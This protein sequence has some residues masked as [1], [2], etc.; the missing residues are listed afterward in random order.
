[1]GFWK[2]RKSLRWSPLLTDSCFTWY[3][4]LLY[5]VPAGAEHLHAQDLRT[6]LPKEK[7]LA[8]SK[9]FVAEADVFVTVRPGGV[10]EVAV[11]PLSHVPSLPAVGGSDEG[12]AA[13][14]TSEAIGDAA[15]PQDAS[16]VEGIS[17]A[18]AGDAAGPVPAQDLARLAEYQCASDRSIP[19]TGCVECTMSSAC[20]CT[21]FVKMGYGD[22]WSEWIPS[23]G[24]TSCSPTNFGGDPLPGQG[25]V[26]MCQ[27]QAFVCATDQ[28]TPATGCDDCIMPNVCT[29]DGKVR[30]GFGTA[31]TPWVQT[32]GPIDCNTDS[33]NADPFPGHAKQ[34]QCR[35]SV[36]ALTA[37]L[38]EQTRPLV[39][40]A[41][42]SAIVVVCT[43]YFFIHAALAC[44]RSNNQFAN[45]PPT[46]LERELESTVSWQS[47]FGPMLCS[48]LLTARQRVQT[49]TA[50]HPQEYGY[51][52]HYL[53]RAAV[54]CTLAYVAL[55]LCHFLSEVNAQATAQIPAHEVHANTSPIGSLSSTTLVHVQT[56]SQVRATKFWQRASHLCNFVAYGCL[57]V[58]IVGVS[59]LKEPPELMV[60]AGR[61]P[62]RIGTLC[63]LVL[64]CGY[65]TVY[66]VLFAVRLAAVAQMERGGPHTTFGLEVMKLGAS[67][68]NVAPMICAL[69]VGLQLS[70]D[71][72]ALKLPTEAPFYM[73]VCTAS[74]VMQV[75]LL[76]IAPFLAKAELQATGPRGELDFVT[77][78]HH[79]FVFISMVRWLAMTA[80][81]IGV[82]WFALVLLKLDGLPALMQ[83]LCELAGVYFFAYL[84]LWA[85]VTAQ[86]VFCDGLAHIVRAFTVAKDTVVFCPMLAVLCIAAWARAHEFDT[87]S[88]QVGQPQGYV[89]SSIK[90]SITAVA[91]QLI[92]VIVS[93]AVLRPPPAGGVYQ[94]PCEKMGFTQPF[95]IV[96][97]IALIVLHSSVV[98]TIVGICLLRPQNATGFESMFQAIPAS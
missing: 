2:A 82:G 22:I 20:A 12:T 80:L 55:I 8:A 57:T 26:C 76:I 96:Y 40:D 63:S 65:F 17:I 33:F 84:M 73:L 41:S 21:G 16:A 78:N 5:A 47:Y 94:D 34:C 37:S 69:F 70:A 24:N 38:V 66:L 71:W 28:L 49:L 13:A 39:M 48:L 72:L 6:L 15:I 11:H 19:T 7:L 83:P 59:N 58:I 14:T 61:T 60:A 88:G 30:F 92:V 62:A 87:P 86:T 10:T 64:A 25:K 4:A 18:S 29:C 95:F 91:V 35:P 74:V 81:Y 32:S 56:P 52:P 51:P 43:A 79:I 42:L 44:V 46:P 31:W 53:D 97:H 3:L 54:V 85:S 67:A 50:G 1:M 9:G 98:L 36:A 77:R 68:A 89:Q 75:V 93:G 23:D 45:I 27:P 90:V